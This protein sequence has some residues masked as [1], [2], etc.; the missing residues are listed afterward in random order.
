MIW[1]SWQPLKAQYGK[2]NAAFKAIFLTNALDGSEDAFV[3][4]G[5]YA[6]IGSDIVA[7]RERLMVPIVCDVDSTATTIYCRVLPNFQLPF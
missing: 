3:S 6:S 4:T 5:L 1:D 2:W 7:I